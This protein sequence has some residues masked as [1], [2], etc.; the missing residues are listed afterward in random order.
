MISRY[1]QF[2]LLIRRD[3]VT[4]NFKAVLQTTRDLLNLAQVGRAVPEWLHKVF[5]GMGDPASAHYSHLTAPQTLDFT[6]TF[7]SAAH[8]VAAF[9][10]YEVVFRTKTG[11]LLSVDTAKPPFRLTFPSPNDDDDDDDD[12][13]NTTSTLKKKKIL[14]CTP[15][16]APQTDPYLPPELRDIDT[17]RGNPIEFTAAQA[18]A[19]RSGMS[20]GL[21]LVVG[22]PG[23]GKTDVV[24]Q[25]VA[26][27]YHSFPEQRILVV[28]R[29]NQALNDLF[30]KIASRSIQS[31]HVL[32][33][34]LGERDLDAEEDFSRLGRVD[35]CLQRREKLL[36]VVK[37][38]AVSVGA[39]E[40]VAYSCETAATF[41][42]SILL[43]QMILFQRAL[44]GRCSEEEKNQ[45]RQVPANY[46]AVQQAEVKQWDELNGSE[47]GL[48]FPFKLFFL[49]LQQPIF[50]SHLSIAEQAKIGDACVKTIGDLF[51]ELKEYRPFELLRHSRHRADYMLASE[52][53]IIAMTCTHAAIARQ[54]LVETGFHFDTLVLEEAGQ[55]LE[56]ESFIP[57]LL[58]VSGVIGKHGI[59]RIIRIIFILH[60]SIDKYGV[61]K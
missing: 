48:L 45:L 57:M 51:T 47:A 4:N 17:T 50:P 25:T 60:Y 43:P 58:Q 20:A 2:N 33:L 49:P 36:E 31:R 5:L 23:T 19:I 21:T 11:E 41:F 53:R 1:E 42:A 56:L 27:L 26:N 7:L 13:D 37:R 18:E 39:T 6:D 55:V 24:V 35:L 34:G 44:Q 46:S 22:P 52:A 30:T 3:P 54:R 40:D 28:T 8:V 14:I 29:S 16:P 15:Y 38:L 32:R 59:I 61:I 12:D 10:Q 9:P